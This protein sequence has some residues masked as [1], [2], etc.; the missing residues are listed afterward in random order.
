MVT[1]GRAITYTADL[2]GSCNVSNANFKNQEEEV[3]IMTRMS[4]EL[5]HG[6]VNLQSSKPVCKH[7]FAQLFEFLHQHD[8]YLSSANF[9]YWIV[10][11][12]A[13]VPLQEG[14][15]VVLCKVGHDL[16]TWGSVFN[17]TV[18]WNANVM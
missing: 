14:E 17:Q 1:V 5:G 6:F 16:I 15:C 2:S 18:R 13:S 4:T 3:L 12:L 9:Y 7:F 10:S 8:Q 11:G